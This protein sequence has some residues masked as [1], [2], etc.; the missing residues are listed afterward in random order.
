MSDF[1]NPVLYNEGHSFV[2]NYGK[3]L[4]ELLELKEDD[5]VLDLGCGTGELS[6]EIFRKTQNLIAI[7]SSKKMLESAREKYPEIN[8]IKMD[9][10]EMDYEKKFDKVFSNAAF[11][12]ISDHE[13]LLGNVYRS[14]KP[15]GM[16]VVE[17][18]GKDNGKTILDSLKKAVAKRGFIENSE[19]QILY[20]PSVAEYT[21]LL[22]KNGFTVYYV[23]YFDRDTELVGKDG[24]KNFIKMFY[25]AY[26]NG[27]D[28]K[29][30]E[31]ILEDVEEECR[32]KLYKNGKWYADY[33]RLRFVAKKF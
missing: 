12:W 17:M 6:N 26:L 25:T 20:F 7:D 24:I 13:K 9:A 22:E 14:L 15:L 1:W 21:N 27:I 28:E 23:L 10:L 31:E 3:V 18:G 19:K 29:T 32:K 11:H 8:F 16:L 4:L 5:E 30:T 2:Y 33:K